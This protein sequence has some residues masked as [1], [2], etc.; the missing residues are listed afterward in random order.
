MPETGRT[1]WEVLGITDTATFSDVKRAYFRR[2]R[3]CHPDA[4]GGGAEAFQEIQAAFEAL[5]RVASSDERSARPSRG[6]PYNSW[7]ARP[8]TPRQWTDDD[9]VLT[10]NAVTF[11]SIQR[12]TFVDVLVAEMRR[13]PLQAA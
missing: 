5:R 1:P 6:T 8:R 7:L 12:T 4:P 10:Q 11:T 13:L 3:R 9:R 2:V